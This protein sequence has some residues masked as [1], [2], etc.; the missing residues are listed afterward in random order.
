[1]GKSKWG[2]DLPG[3]LGRRLISD[4]AVQCSR[5]ESRLCVCGGRVGIV[6]WGQAGSYQPNNL[7]HISK[8]LH[9]SV[10]LSFLISNMEITVL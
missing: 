7:G 8:P 4:R 3:Q 1:M 9:Y 6:G 5:Y 2:P 10:A